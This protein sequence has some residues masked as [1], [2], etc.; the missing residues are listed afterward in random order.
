MYNLSLDELNKS[1]TES[2]GPIMEGEEIAVNQFCRDWQPKETDATYCPVYMYL[3]NG[4]RVFYTFL[5]DVIV[6]VDEYTVLIDTLLTANE[7]D[8]YYIFI[9]SPGGLIASGGII[10]SAIHH[11]KA[12]VYTYAHGLCA[13]AAALIH[14]SAKK[15]NAMV[16][17][18][19]V[20]MYHMSM[21]HDSGTSTA[22]ASRAANQVRYVNE[23]LL[24]KA[25]AEGHITEK[26][27]E[28]IQFGEEIFITADEF[29]KRTKG[30]E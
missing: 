8:K 22:I 13:S 5:T 26:E 30:G 19:A 20:L 29:N 16:S 24:N 17:P 12:E 15:E 28:R 7:G 3:E 11:S 6:D 4:N 10:A 23:C 21:H 2:I 25:L 14:S 9:D 1:A 27:L 18:Y